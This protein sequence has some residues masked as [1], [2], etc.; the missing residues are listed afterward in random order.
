MIDLRSDTVTKP[1]P[2]MLEAMF[3]A[4]VGDDVFREDP[5]VIELEEK[6]AQKFG[7]EDG[8]FC[9]SG[10]MA[11]QIAI[12]AHTQPGDELLC[13]AL[14]HIYNYEGGG[15]SFNSG[16]QAKLLQ[17]NLGRFTARQVE[18]NI[19]P[20]QDWLC[21]TAL[22]AVENTVNRAGGSY[23]NLAQLKEIAEVCKKNKIRFHM[24]GARIFNA[25]T[26]TKENP[27]AYSLL[28]DSIS[29]CFSKG[30]GTPA[31]SVLIGK[32]EFIRQARR[33][34][35]VLGGGMRQAGFLAAAAVYALENNILRLKEDHQRA[36]R[37]AEVV[38]SLPFVESTF[39]VDT[40]II[41]FSLSDRIKPEDF[42]DRLAQNKIR[43]SGFGKQSIRMVTHI[44]FND[45]MLGKTIEV[46]KNL[47]M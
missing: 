18:E 46:L 40:N 10:T 42:T 33:I 37:L 43:V 2:G 4:K 14:A 26:E 5:T 17:G 3:S 20:L 47:P 30:L 27:A 25:L 22:V 12:K 1:G 32:K 38:R 45:D 28:F 9:P 13:D 23:Y 41:I 6:T 24:D 16:V 19:N 11:N 29:V 15:I 8:L 21:R 35:K 34:R 39:P 31:G 7:M 44:D 36:K